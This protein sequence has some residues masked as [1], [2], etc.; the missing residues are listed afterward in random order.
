[1]T[2]HRPGFVAFALLAT[3]LTAGPRASAGGAKVQLTVKDVPM[4]P[5]DPQI[6]PKS[7]VF[8]P[9]GKHIAYVAKHGSGHV[10]LVD[11]KTEKEYEVVALPILFSPDGARH[12]YKATRGGAWTYVVDGKEGAWHPGIQDTSGDF[13]ADGTHFAYLA[14]KTDGAKLEGGMSPTVVVTDGVEGDPYFSIESESFEFGPVGA[15]PTFVATRGNPPK[16]KPFAVVAGQAGHPY[17]EVGPVVFSSNGKAWGHFAAEGGSSFVVVNGTEGRHYSGIASPTFSADGTRWAHR[18]M[19]KNK[20]LVVVNGEDGAEYDEIPTDTLLVS[21]DGAHV[22]YAARRGTE[23]MVV[24]DGVAGKAYPRLG[25]TSLRF[26]HEGDHL[27][28]WAGIGAKPFYVVDGVEQKPYDQ[29]A[30][31]EVKRET[32]FRFSADGKHT[33][34]IAQQGG[35]WVVV[36]DGVEVGAYEDTGRGTLCFSPGAEHLA[37]SAKSKGNWVLV[38][39]GSENAGDYGNLVTDAPFGFDGP[40]A[41]HAVM[42]RGTTIVRIEV[43]VHADPN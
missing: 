23:W 7:L 21:R 12:A 17:D 20:W 24:R 32:A 43:D 13:S 4:S 8:T 5:L 14:S 38:V 41:L 27:A 10:A 40:Q 26:S 30:N 39:D 2:N 3:V 31:D 1:M 35:L 34:Y 22:A 42:V 33:A 6:D 36:R 16:E 25:A 29:L 28:Y 37:C 11:G 15:V 9:D 19:K 18:A